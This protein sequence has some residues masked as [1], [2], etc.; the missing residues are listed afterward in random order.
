ML[1]K[2][3]ITDFVITIHLFHVIIIEL[4]RQKHIYSIIMPESK[5]IM[6]SKITSNRYR[7]KG[8]LTTSHPK[9]GRKSLTTASLLKP[10]S[11]MTVVTP[12]DRPKLVRNR[13]V[14][15]VLVAFLCC[16]LGFR[17]FC[18]YRVFVIGL[19]QICFFSL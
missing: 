7:H 11:W 12:T 8:G 3:I 6:S 4:K 5:T 9:R 19:S 16:P 2:P 14:I 10:N 17:I 13:C 15:E 1:F 18:W